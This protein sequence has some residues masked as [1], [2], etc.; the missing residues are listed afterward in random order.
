MTFLTI[1]GTAL[2]V[3]IVHLAIT[4]EQLMICVSGCN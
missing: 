1:F 2:V 3:H 4:G